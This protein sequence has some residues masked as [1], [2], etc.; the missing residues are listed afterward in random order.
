[1]TIQVGDF[2]QLSDDHAR[3]DMTDGVGTRDGSLRTSFDYGRV[4]GLDARSKLIEVTSIT[5]LDAE[6][7][8]IKWSYGSRQLKRADPAVGKY[9]LPRARALWLFSMP[10]FHL[11]MVCL[12]PVTCVH[13][14]ADVLGS[15]RSKYRPP[16][17]L[18]TMSQNTN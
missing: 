13:Q 12:L 14:A 11:R 2:V 5:R 10:L 16:P 1:M 8:A 18:Y 3:F 7:A 9:F 17:L 15:T 4:S 6:G